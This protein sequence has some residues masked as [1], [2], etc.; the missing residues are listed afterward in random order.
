MD[1][2]VVLVRFPEVSSGVFLCGFAALRAKKKV[3]YLLSEHDFDDLKDGQ[4]G[5]WG[6]ISRG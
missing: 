1:R 5:G 6:K 4:D 2:M 3:T